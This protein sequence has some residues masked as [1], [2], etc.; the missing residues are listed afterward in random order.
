MPR[1]PMEC[2]GCGHVLRATDPRCSRC[3][4]LKPGDGW[5]PLAP[6][7]AQVLR[8]HAE[9][10]EG[11][12][13][14]AGMPGMVTRLPAQAADAPEDVVEPGQM[15]GM[16]DA[17]DTQEQP[18]ARPSPLR[19]RIS[20]PGRN[21]DST[22][23]LLVEDLFD[24][25]LTEES[26]PPTRATGESPIGQ[27]YARRYRMEERLPSCPGADRFVAMQEP[28]VRRVVLTVLLRIRAPDVQQTLETR[29]LREASVLAR[30]RHPNLATVHDF[31]RSGDGT[32]FATE[33]L[34][35]GFTLRDLAERGALPTERLVA[36]AADVV[37]AL[38][39][40]HEAGVVHRAVRP[41]HVV[42][43]PRT[44]RGGTGSETAQLGRVGF[45]VTLEDIGASMDTEAALA[46]PPEVI[47]GQEPD[48]TADVYAMGVLL[49]RLLAGRPPYPGTAAEVMV[50]RTRGDPPPL[51]R[52]GNGSLSDRLSA[53]AE[54]CLRASPDQRYGT[55]RELLVELEVFAGADELP[56]AAPS[57]AP[58][59]P[60]LT[61]RGMFV[62]AIAGAIIPTIALVALGVTGAL[63]ED[64]PLVVVSTPPSAPVA[65]A[66]P[67]QPA[68]TV[69][70]V[71]PP[72]EPVPPPAAPT[73]IEATPPPAIPPARTPP[74]RTRP[75]EPA[76]VAA[77]P[78]ES[79]PAPAP[80][81]PEVPAPKTVAAS[82]SAPERPPAPPPGA[83]VPGAAALSG[84]WLGRAGGGSLALD[85]TVDRAGLVSGRAKRSDGGT[86][87]AVRGRVSATE[88][89]LQVELQVTE[90][91]AT[92]TY[93][94]VVVDGAL[95]GKMYSGGKAQGRFTA[96]R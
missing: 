70:T 4:Q 96:Q 92:T 88:T 31:G 57:P 94:G 91:G 95:R 44:W 64:P 72:A 90:G 71:A 18:T 54:G 47:E 23:P 37:S 78:P 28:L 6:A 19:L 66:S 16:G 77:S 30:L 51:P 84:L 8:L 17:E 81:P 93:S 38:C 86:E 58:R 74:R 55:A 45:E 62:A 25:G 35:Y 42:V 32:C 80:V 9:S 63:R 68:P 21:E 14:V 24:G 26:P 82:V 52:D 43:G 76:P 34:L 49:Y 40:L 36:L 15:M 87:G 39:A 85:L 7:K 65:V 1:D 12:V 89:G 5:A 29:F 75:P 79:V 20:S 60:D 67:A 50:A 53:V 61:P 11:M 10:V 83:E 59:P 69:A 41:E 2:T 27:M 46:L 13:P 73:H 22:E 56:V 48:E 33:E 3:G